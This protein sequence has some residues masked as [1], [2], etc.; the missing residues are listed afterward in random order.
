MIVVTVNDSDNDRY[1]KH[2]TY[3][4]ICNNRNNAITNAASN[5]NNADHHIINPHST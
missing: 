5:D 3:V 4:M 1:N 2:S